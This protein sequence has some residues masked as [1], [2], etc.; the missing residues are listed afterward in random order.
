VRLRDALI[1]GPLAPADK[2]VAIDL[3][4]GLLP[5]VDLYGARQTDMKVHHF[6]LHDVRRMTP[7]EFPLVP[8]VELLKGQVGRCGG[9]RPRWRE[10]TVH[11][12]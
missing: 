11:D 6:D 3:K 4:P 10:R 8:V 9:A 5:D 12:R 2:P 7:V 1:P